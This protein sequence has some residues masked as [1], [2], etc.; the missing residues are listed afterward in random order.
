MPFNHGIMKSQIMIMTVT[1]VCLAECVD[2]TNRSVRYN[3][4]FYLHTYIT[5]IISYIYNVLYIV[6]SVGYYMLLLCK[7]KGR[8]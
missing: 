1:P 3:V 4:L 8:A 2:I 7:L 5:Y 6:I